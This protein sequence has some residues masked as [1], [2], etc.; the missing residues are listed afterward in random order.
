MKI[1][2][3]FMLMLLLMFMSQ[4]GY[5]QS[6]KDY[7]F[8]GYWRLGVNT[9]ANLL[10]EVSD[11]QGEHKIFHNIPTTR[12]AR[13]PNYFWLQLIKNFDQGIVAV[14]K[15]DSELDA[16]PHESNQWNKSELRIRDLYLQLPLFDNSSYLWFGSRVFE[17]ESIRL[18][19]KLNHFDLNAHGVGLKLWNTD[20]VLSFTK[21]D[22]LNDKD[23]STCR[24][25]K[26]VTFLFRHEVLLG[27]GLALKPMFKFINYGTLPEDNQDPTN[28]PE[29][30]GTTAYSI[31]GVLSRW[32]GK[33]WGNTMVWV[34]SRPVDNYGDK[35]GRDTLLGI[36][37]SCNYDFE[38]FGLLL[39]AF[40]E[41]NQFNDKQQVYKVKSGSLVQDE[42]NTTKS[43]VKLSLGVQ[44]VYY[45]T[46]R[47]HAA[48]DINKTYQDKYINDYSFS[49]FLITPILRY[50]LDKTP[51]GVP[52]IYTSITYGQY[53]WKAK[54]K[55]NS[56]LTD[57]LI[58]TQSG[59]EI[60]F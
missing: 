58:T 20:L 29:I 60:W 13:G 12:H 51:I 25:R 27:E 56:E 36:A 8:H 11:T 55:G 48:L 3:T 46:S 39:G 37:E 31:G 4:F 38:Y 49:S 26:N 7:E 59:F 54:K 40:L 57:N 47:L 1:N 32:S 5:S 35:S 50:S 19:D 53:D 44:P 14:F 9:D 52:Q 21:D 10:D 34:E 43:V 30:K 23:E 42:D 45:I 16:M 6:H 17:F 24:Y 15:I 18:F 22:V 28:K 2:K 41:F 33:D